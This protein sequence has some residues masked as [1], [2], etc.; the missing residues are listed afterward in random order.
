MI[1]YK[2]MRSNAGPLKRNNRK[3]SVPS[4]NLLTEGNTLAADIYSVRPNGEVFH[5]VLPFAA[6]GAAE[7][8]R[9]LT[10]AT[11]A[12]FCTKHG[13]AFITDID[14][15]WPCNEAPNLIL[16]FATEGTKVCSLP[17][18]ESHR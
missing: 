2:Y 16:I 11:L 5:L 17:F 4:Y 7:S 10:F 18:S 6:E 14:T 9:L 1:K 15:S 12:I 8:T 3:D 13:N